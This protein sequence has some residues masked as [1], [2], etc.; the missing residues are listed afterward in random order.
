MGTMQRP[1]QSGATAN[2]P[3]IFFFWAVIHNVQQQFNIKAMM[4][5][6]PAHWGKST[7]T[8]I[9]NIQLQ[10]PGTQHTHTNK[11][12]LTHNKVQL[13]LNWKIIKNVQ[14]ITL[15]EMYLKKIL[16]SDIQIN[17]YI[18]LHAD[19][20]LGRKNWGIKATGAHNADYNV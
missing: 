15:T 4:S 17:N 13:I 10:H 20:T 14:A 3:N 8:A 2:N 11:V 12:Q 19:Q 6:T 5:P 18:G 9:F 1:T 16:D 7:Y